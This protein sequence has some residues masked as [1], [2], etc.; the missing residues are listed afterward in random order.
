MPQPFLPPAEAFQGSNLPYAVLLSSQLAILTAMFYLTFRMQTGAMVPSRR[1]G[2]GLA[3]AGGIYMAL[4]IGRIAVGLALPEADP[5]FSA[6]IPAFF[7]S[8]LAGFVLT[9]SLYHLRTGRGT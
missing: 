4:S 9:V 1:I 8:V 7:H 5:W 6:W 2:L 3:W